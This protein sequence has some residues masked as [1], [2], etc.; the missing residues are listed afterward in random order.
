MSLLLSL[1]VLIIL[2]EVISG[3]ALGGDTID[4]L[5][6]EGADTP[7]MNLEGF[8]SDLDEDDRLRACMA[9][10]VKMCTSSERNDSCDLVCDNFYVLLNRVDFPR[11]GDRGIVKRSTCYTVVWDGI[12][13]VVLICSSR[14]Y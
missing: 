14:L 9:R 2:L 12:N 7:L 11:Y 1:Q 4:W 3:L 6:A 8:G 10:M 13:I 5:V